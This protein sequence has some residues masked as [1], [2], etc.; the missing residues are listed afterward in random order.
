MK[1]LLLAIFI[2]SSLVACE[3]PVEGVGEDSTYLD[4]YFNN[5]D[6][7]KDTPEFHA[8]KEDTTWKA[9]SFNYMKET[10]KIIIN[11]TKD[12]ETLKLVV[13]GEGAGNFPLLITNPDDLNDTFGAIYTNNNGKVYISTEGTNYL[14]ITLLDADSNK[15]T[16]DFELNL[17]NTSNPDDVITW[18]NGKFKNVSPAQE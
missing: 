3:D 12:G 4:D 5:N 18:T 1:K 2:F 10:G 6:P 14:N 15:M 9:T 8:N 16:G 17:V 13:A 11:A 7:N